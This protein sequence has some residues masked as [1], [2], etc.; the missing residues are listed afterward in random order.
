MSEL[1][2]DGGVQL[3][4]HAILENDYMPPNAADFIDGLGINAIR[5]LNRSASHVTNN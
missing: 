2:T 5:M 4:G 1:R 3:L